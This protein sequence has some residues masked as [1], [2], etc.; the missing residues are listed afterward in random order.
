MSA[1]QP[2]N[3]PQATSASDRRHAPPDDS[4]VVYFEGRPMFGGRPGRVLGFLT[5]GVL[6]A[7][8]PVLLHYRM[9]HWPAEWVLIATGFIALVLILSPLLMIKTIRYRITNYR[10]DL[11]RG[12]ISKDITSLELWHV[13]DLAFH[14]SLLDRFIG[15]GSIRVMSHDQTLPNLRMRGLP[16][17]R[18]LFEE[19]K[20]RVIAVKR[21]TGVM[22]VDTGT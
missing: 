8:I 2:V 9:G 15:T 14:Q 22:K 7:L 3:V 17:A 21:Q 12:F 18:H 20:C 5:L 10:I 1:G 4:E 13:E 6:V 16:G 11:E 19:I